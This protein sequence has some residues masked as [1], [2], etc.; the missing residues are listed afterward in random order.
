MA[1]VGQVRR[2]DE[3]K[4]GRWKEKEVRMYLYIIQNVL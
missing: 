2:K 3:R 1:S 4:I